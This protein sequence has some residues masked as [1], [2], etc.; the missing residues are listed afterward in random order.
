MDRKQRRCSIGCD[1][2]MVRFTVHNVYY[3]LL[4]GVYMSR[5]F[6][7]HWQDRL[8]ESRIRIDS[9]FLKEMLQRSISTV[10]DIG[11]G[12]GKKIETLARLGFR[13]TCVDYSVEASHVLHRLSQDPLIKHLNVVCADILSLPFHSSSFGA[14]TSFNVMNFFLNE[15][16]RRRVF[17]ET[18][19]VLRPGGIMLIVVM[20][21]EDEGAKVGK[22]LG[23][24][25]FHLPEGICLH[26]FTPSEMEELL[27]G[28]TIVRFNCFE[29]I[30]RTHDTPHTHSLIYVLAS[31]D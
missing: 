13:I 31:N 23:N 21:S 17:K 26:Y 4:E 28:M 6:W 30:D 22:S 3:C 9:F 11:S 10:L 8:T 2:E 16:E 7:N 5:E 29:S 15:P 19:R 18:L 12:S 24:R 20:S 14:V 25:N 1:V 27:E